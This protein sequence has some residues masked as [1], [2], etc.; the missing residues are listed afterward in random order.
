MRTVIER[1]GVLGVGPA[2]VFGGKLDIGLAIPLGRKILSFLELGALCALWT[3][4]RGII[5]CLYAVSRAAL[6][7][8]CLKLIL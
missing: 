4:H 7:L 6:R 3:S 5:D 2:Y 1:H 8:V